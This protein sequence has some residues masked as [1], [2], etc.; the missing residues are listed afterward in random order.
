MTIGNNWIY[1]T[2]SHPPSYDHLREKALAQVNFDDDWIYFTSNL[3]PFP[4]NSLQ[5]IGVFKP[6]FVY[7]C[8]ESRLFARDL[9]VVGPLS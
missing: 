2:L 8:N 4:S 9:E 5:R 1:F 3:T 7:K 6:Q